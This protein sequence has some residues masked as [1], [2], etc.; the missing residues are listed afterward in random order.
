MSGSVQ[1]TLLLPLAILVLLATLQWSLLLWAESTAMAAAQDSARAAAVLGGSGEDGREAGRR[2]LA[3]SAL[4][5]ADV[6][7]D[8]AATF[9][10]SVVEGTAIRVLPMVDVTVHQEAR[11]PTERTR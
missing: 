10:T 4:G 7:V 5:D 1:V 2:A 6:R 3:N 8:R 9:T 11:V